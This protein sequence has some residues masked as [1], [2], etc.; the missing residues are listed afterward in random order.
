MLQQYLDAA[1]KEKERYLKELNQYKQTDAYKIF[2]EKQAAEKKKKVSKDKDKDKQEREK[3]GVILHS[4]SS[5]VSIL[6]KT[7]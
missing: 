3:N 1:E 7:M 2:M 6:I 5:S 4:E